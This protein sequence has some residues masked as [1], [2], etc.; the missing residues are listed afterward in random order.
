LY[1]SRIQHHRLGHAALEEWPDAGGDLRGHLS[2]FMFPYEGMPVPAQYIA[3]VLPVTHFMRTIRAL[4][5][6]GAGL[7]EVAFDTFWLV[8]FMLV[9]LLVAWLRFKK[10]LD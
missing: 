3:G 1:E 2:D 6:R 8:G 5:L 4:V 7:H 10:R 9:G